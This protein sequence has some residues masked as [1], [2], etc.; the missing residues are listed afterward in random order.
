M[1]CFAVILMILGI[2]LIIFSVWAE[3]K[4]LEYSG[5]LQS[6]ISAAKEYSAAVLDITDEKGKKAA[7][8]QIRIEEQ[9]RTIVHRC[10]EPFRSDYKRGDRITVYFIEGMPAD[11][12]VIK[13]DN[14]YERFISTEKK[15]RLAERLCGGA[16]AVIGIILLIIR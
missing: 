1:V 8:I 2:A 9:K 16:A 15:Y 7:I 12:S 10:T 11:R 5:K 13:G 6:F 14:T 3:K 4:S